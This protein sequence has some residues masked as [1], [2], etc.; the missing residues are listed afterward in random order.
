MH[1]YASDSADRKFAPWIIAAISIL[2][3][4][5]YAA[6][7]LA[8]EFSLPWWC[9]TPTIMFVYGLL[10][11]IY[12]KWIWKKNIC[13]LSLSQIPD[14]NGT[15]Y[16]ELKSSHEGGTNVTGI[17]IVNQ[18]WNKIVI[19]FQT[20]FSTS[21]SRMASLNITP[22]PSEGLIYEYTNDPNSDAAETMHSHKGFAFLRLSS[23]RKLL[24]GDYYSGRDRANFGTMKFHFVSKN[25]LR[26]NDAKNIYEKPSEGIR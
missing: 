1:A 3:A 9:E 8:Y 10:H 7:S 12:N 4:Y 16:G 22:G 15:W 5:L 21:F 13:G 24:E 25:S 2:I 23:D 20:N 6:I 18:T 19:K 17:L 14:C 26:L 11:L